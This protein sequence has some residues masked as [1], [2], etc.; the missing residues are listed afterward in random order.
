M[1]LRHLELEQATQE[2]LVGSADVDLGAARRAPHLEHVGL[3]ILADPI[4]LDGGLLRG[5]Q[6]RL[7]TLPDVENDRPRLHPVDSAR[8]HLA[9]A[10]GEL[11]EHD[12]PL[13]LPQPLQDHLLGGLRVDP[14]ECLRIELL[15][16]DEV[17]D[18]GI[19]LV[20]VRLVDGQ[21]RRNTRILPVSAS[22]RTW[23]SSPPETR[24]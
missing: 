22:I 12:V 17:A 21:L 2:A 8:D 18:S 9:L 6:D 5:G 24:R 15:R 13:R 14:A 1:D 10:A 4:V 16:L 7:D 20:A 3:H 19:C 23:M 11:V